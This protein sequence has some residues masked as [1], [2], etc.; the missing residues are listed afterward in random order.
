MFPG[1]GVLIVF[2]KKPNNNVGSGTRQGV[3]HVK[4]KREWKARRRMLGI[5]SLT[6]LASGIHTK[7]D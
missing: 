4:L 6:L 1:A 5:F 2:A 3:P 7:E